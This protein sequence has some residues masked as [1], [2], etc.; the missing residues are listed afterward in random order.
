MPYGVLIPSVMLCAMACAVLSQRMVLLVYARSMGCAV[1]SLRMVLLAYILV[2]AVLSWRMGLQA[3]C[4]S[5]PSSSS[6]LCE[7][8][9]RT[10]LRYYYLAAPASTVCRSQIA[11]TTNR[12]MPY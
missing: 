6:S 9:L 1:L 3:S 12:C 8:T 11:Y 4:I 10:V 2:W 5:Q 7:S